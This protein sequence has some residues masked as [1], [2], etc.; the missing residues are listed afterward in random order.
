VAIKGI[1]F[2]ERNWYVPKDDPDRRDTLEESLEAG[3]TV[4]YWSAI[5]NM[6]MT[7][8]NDMQSSSKITMGAEM[9]QEFRQRTAMRNREAFRYG[10]T[11]WDNYFDEKGEQ[12]KFESKTEMRGQQTFRVVSEDSLNCVRLSTMQEVGAHVFNSN[13]MGDEDRKK[14][15]AVLSPFENSLT[16][17][18]ANAANETSESE[19]ATMTQS[20]TATSP[21]D[22]T[23]QKKSSGSTRRQT[24]KSTAAQGD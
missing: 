20:S 16:G 13:S 18:V 2:T 8:I 6:I 22:P 24:K 4:F 11:G 21:K 7:D 15:E 3:A 9:S 1:S 10:I 12:I 17:L 23:T 19:D 5:P 14:L